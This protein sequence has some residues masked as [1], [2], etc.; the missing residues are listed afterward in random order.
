[1]SPLKRDWCQ[2][3]PILHGIDFTLREVTLADASPLL[4][5]TSGD[6]VNRYI[7]PPPDTQEDFEQF[8]E[9]AR[10]RR[11]D[12]QFACFGL[13]PA[14]S[15]WP[16]G[17]FQ[18]RPD[19]PSYETAEWGFVFAARTWGSGLFESGAREVIDFAF[20]IMGVRRLDAR[21]AVANGRG[22]GGLLKL[23]AVKGDV[24]KNGFILKGVALD[25]NM[26][27]I[28]ERDWHRS[29]AVWGP[30]VAA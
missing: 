22:N 3:L 12:G 1:M 9:W 17:M 25:L 15:K 28:L 19:D 27:S 26:W 5:A 23:G 20:D 11:Q 29:K 16:V 18:I 8:I 4:E 30:K 2:T 6:E 13:V 14:G 24:V 7:T 21:A 10:S